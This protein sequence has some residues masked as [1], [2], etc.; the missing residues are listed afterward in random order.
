MSLRRH[1][2][3]PEVD[4]ILH[5]QLLRASQ[6]VE[7]YR[8]VI[9][10]LAEELADKGEI[11]GEAV[12]A[13]VLDHGKPLQFALAQSAEIPRTLATRSDKGDFTKDSPNPSAQR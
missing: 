4:A 11:S 5:E 6:L 3:E 9:E 8:D 10:R 12:V 1:R 13:A 2:L 7:R